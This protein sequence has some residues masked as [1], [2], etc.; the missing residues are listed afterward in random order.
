M[1][2][3]ILIYLDAISSLLI[4][5]LALFS[6]ISVRRE[7]VLIFIAVQAVLNTTAVI[8]DQWFNQPNLFVYH[9]NC[10]LSVFIL[11]RY[12]ESILS[13]SRIRLFSAITLVVFYSFYLLTFFLDEGFATFN[14][15]SFGLASLLIVIFCLLYY[16]Q[17]IKHPTTSRIIKS[18]DFWYVTGIL[19]YYTCNFFIFISYRVLTQSHIEHVGILWKIHNVFFLMMCLYIFAGMLCKPSPKKFKLL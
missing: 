5:F 16:W 8:M 2:Y 15:K 1:V 19:T 17:N 6:K 18:R 3:G 12:F 11:V 14:S 9:I 7:G 10:L 13:I 4:F